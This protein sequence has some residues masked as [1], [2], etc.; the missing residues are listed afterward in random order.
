MCEH[1]YNKVEKIQNQ[2]HHYSQALPNGIEN[3]KTAKR[4]VFIEGD[5]GHWVTVSFLSRLLSQ[6]HA[7]CIQD[8]LQITVKLSFH[9][10][11]KN[12][13]MICFFQQLSTSGAD[14]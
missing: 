9:S 4:L 7:M 8:V 1:I 13:L 14:R 12:Q 3:F 2:L 11:C 5:R 10:L 6:S